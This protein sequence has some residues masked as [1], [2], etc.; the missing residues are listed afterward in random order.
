MSPGRARKLITTSAPPQGRLLRGSG[1]GEPMIRRRA[2][3]ASPVV[4]QALG[5]KL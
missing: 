1:S 5:S 2:S 3:I 4:L